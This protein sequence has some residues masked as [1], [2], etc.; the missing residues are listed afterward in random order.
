MPWR[1]IIY[2]ILFL[3]SLNEKLQFQQFSDFNLFNQR[4][5]CSYMKEFLKCVCFLQWIK[6]INQSI[7]A[8]SRHHRCLL[9]ARCDIFGLESGA[10]EWC[11]YNW[12]IHIRRMTN[13][14]LRR[15]ESNQWTHNDLLL[16]STDVLDPAVSSHHC[17][18]F[19]QQG[20]SMLEQFFLNVG[21]PLQLIQFL[22]SYIHYHSLK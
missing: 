11:I 14:L 19:L 17:R 5:C 4:I 20:C 22:S 12:G 15:R 10:K 1:N 6:Q 18:L 9:Q 8:F 3:E 2:Y 7:S 21:K 13:I 16:E